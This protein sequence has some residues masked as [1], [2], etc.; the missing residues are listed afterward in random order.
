[1]NYIYLVFGGIKVKFEKII[2]IF[3][4]FFSFNNLMANKPVVQLAQSLS[5]VD[6]YDAIRKGDFEKVKKIVEA[7]KSIVNKAE[8]KQE[9]VSE[10]SCGIVLYT[11][12]YIAIS[13]DKDDIAKYFIDNGA[14]LE[15]TSAP[16]KMTSLHC[17][18]K[19]RNLD[20]VE[21]L[22]EKGASV[23]TERG[24]PIAFLHDRKAYGTPLFYAVDSPEIITFLISKGADP[25]VESV[26]N[27]T[28]LTFAA[29]DGDIASVKALVQ[30]GADPQKGYALNQAKHNHYPNVVQY[31]ENEIAKRSQK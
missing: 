15:A 12:L 7:D 29:T 4:L 23:H 5:L 17:A 27:Y 14:N 1:M 9:L 19:K 3:C 31:L 21:Y 28:P 6:F 8:E 13:N 24:G 26:L 2:F 22:V 11:P 16:E 20:M 10:C 25:N 30:G 18:C